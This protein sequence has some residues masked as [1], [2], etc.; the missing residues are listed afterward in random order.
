MRHR[1]YFPRDE[2]PAPAGDNGFVGVNA[3][4]SPDQLPPGV[5]AY[6]RN[7]RF[8]ER[9]AATRKGIVKC[10]WGQRVLSE[11]GIRWPV[12]WNTAHALD[13]FRD[14][15][16]L[17]W[18]L[19]GAEEKVW[20]LRPNN[21]PVAIPQPATV[22][23][24]P[25]VSFVQ[26]FG[27]VYCLRGNH[28]R[29]LVMT[30]IDAG[31][32]YL[33]PTWDSV[34][35]Y[36]TT[37]TVMWGPWT[38]EASGALV[39]SGASATL[40]TTAPH[41]LVTGC[42]V[43]I[44]GTTLPADY[45]GTFLVTVEDS[46]TLTFR[47]NGT[48][49]ASPAH[50][51]EWTTHTAG[52]KVVTGQDPAPGEQPG[53][54]AKW[55]RDYSVLPNGLNG[56][57]L[58]GRLLVPTSWIPGPTANDPAGYS[59]KSDYV[60]ASDVSNQGRFTVANEFRINQGSED[61]LMVLA[62]G[63]TRDV[64]CFK[65]A[66]I[67]ALRDLSGSLGSVTLET[68][69]SPY[70]LVNPRAVA[71]VGRDLAFVAPQRGICTLTQSAQGEVQGVDVP[72]SDPIEPII[73]R[74]H[75]PSASAIRLAYWNNRLYCA[76]PLD[77]ATCV[78]ATQIPP[79][80]PPRDVPTSLAEY[81]TAGVEYEWRPAASGLEGLEVN[82]VQ[83][84]PAQGVQRFV[85][86]GGAALLRYLGE[87]TPDSSF[88]IGSTLRPVRKGV[89]NAIAVY[90]YTAPATAGDDPVWRAL[91]PAGQWSGLDDGPDVSVREFRVATVHGRE[92]LLAL[93]NDGWLSLL[94]ESDDGD[95]TRPVV[96]G[97]NRCVS[98]PIEFEL[99]SRGYGGRETWNRGLRAIV[100]LATWS[101]KYSIKLRADGVREERALREDVR[102][103][104]R[105]L[106]RPAWAARF[107]PYADGAD[108]DQPYREDYSVL[109]DLAITADTTLI[110][111]DDD[112]ITADADARG[113]DVGIRG[114][115]ADR[116]QELQEPLKL[117]ALP[118]RWQQLQI[119]N[120]DGRVEARQIVLESIAGSR[121]DGTKV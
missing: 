55:T 87:P 69:R 33:W 48:G 8:N 1:S 27:R 85:Y 73:K 94:E 11:G 40:T 26:A 112:T 18:L 65:G 66:S 116:L 5:L 82:G 44:R 103:D 99:V 57:F 37:A 46:R 81:L 102:R 75:W 28:R 121:A 32:S 83:Y 53:V 74:I 29:T 43:S 49:A 38:A 15:N 108:L 36:P 95:A 2:A 23:I 58:N 45:Q 77:D 80:T 60:A 72:L 63:S 109:P 93:T 96:Q 86:G 19:L 7:L 34:L 50:A 107:D 76:L 25:P 70:G 68:L 105:R 13:R 4:R 71:T 120:T 79:I 78:G 100:S 9:V 14:P 39:V 52:W 54:S 98:E 12:A 3:K 42:E 114:L 106:T 35:D 21:D 62:K 47:H 30:D 84:L 16:G 111:A 118:G 17:D 91:H 110:T 56:V 61:E 20:R 10:L 104:R 59:A 88:I 97:V 24:G 6:G 41:G 89:N 64:V 117:P 22:W 92:R 119:L 67:L 90:D 51:L 31:W 101:P 115:I 113:F